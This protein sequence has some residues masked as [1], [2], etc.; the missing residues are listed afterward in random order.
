M[1]PMHDE[2][3]EKLHELRAAHRRILDAFQNEYFSDYAPPV[4]IPAGTEIADHAEVELS[5]RSAANRCLDGY[6]REKAEAWHRAR[7][8]GPAA[9]IARAV[10]ESGE[11]G[12]EGD[13]D[14][15]RSIEAIEL[16][17]KEPVTL[18]RQQVRKVRQF[19]VFAI[20]A[21]RVRQAA[22]EAETGRS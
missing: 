13:V 5:L 3:M 1:A 17:A 22:E 6:L 10:L 12:A 21:D 2:R 4:E 15:R 18:T 20:A 9:A 11:T 7:A 14:T 19:A 16:R 8:M